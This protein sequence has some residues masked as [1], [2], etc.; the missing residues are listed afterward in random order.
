[1]PTIVRWFI[2]SSLIYLILAL[3]SGTVLAFERL[4]NIPGSIPQLTPVFIHLL[5]FGWLTQ[6]I[7]GVSIW[8]FPKYTKEMPR[9]SDTLNLATYITLNTGLIMRVVGEPMNALHPFVIWGWVL[10]LSAMLQLSAGAI[11]VIN[12]WGRVK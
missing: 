11:Y 9:G 1:M 3:S 12:I 4:L 10:V 7:M 2:K 6:L 8:M 5:T